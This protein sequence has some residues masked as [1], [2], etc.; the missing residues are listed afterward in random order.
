[1]DK[2]LNREPL[3]SMLMRHYPAL[4]STSLY[5]WKHAAPQHNSRWLL[6]LGLQ[7]LFSFTITDCYK[8][9]SIILLISA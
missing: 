7:P 8:I 9:C 6:C 3:I 4:T 5:F 1:L 2:K